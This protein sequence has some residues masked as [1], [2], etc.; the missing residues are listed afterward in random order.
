MDRPSYDDI[1]IGYARYRR[2][3]PR[4]QAAIDSALG[5][6]G[7]V[8]N[9]GA[10]TG[11][12]EPSDRCVLAVEPSSEMIAQ[13]PPGSAPCL[14]GVAE[15]LRF[16]DD[17]FDAGM[18]LLTVHHWSAPRDGLRELARVARAVVVFTFEPELHNDFWLWRD[19]IPSIAQLP[20]TAGALSVEE[21]ASAIDADRI[22]TVLVPHDC[23]DGFGWAYWRRPKAYLDEEV[24]RCIS[25]FGLAPPDDVRAGMERLGDDL[26]SGRWHDRHAALLNLD[27]IDG[28]FRLVVRDIR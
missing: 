26:D 18:A 8:V 7:T 28:G 21:I 20:T 9:V 25:G 6:A 3:D 5:M 2:P 12:Y 17:A 14:R 19:Y 13:R 11:S 15:A 16:G 27:A 1:G 24:R 22:E 23:V 10:G 4:I